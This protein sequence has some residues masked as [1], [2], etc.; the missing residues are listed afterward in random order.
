ML[1]EDALGAVIRSAGDQLILPERYVVDAERLFQAGRARS[2]A[3]STVMWTVFCFLL[4]A[5]TVVL[6]S[7]NGSVRTIAGVPIPAILVAG[8]FGTFVVLL[9][10]I[11][12]LYRRVRRLASR[13]RL[14]LFL[15]GATPCSRQFIAIT[16][17]S[18]TLFHRSGRVSGN[19]PFREVIVTAL[20]Q[21]GP[22]VSLVVATEDTFSEIPIAL[23]IG[24]PT[25]PFWSSGGILGRHE[26]CDALRDDLRESGYSLASV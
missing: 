21:F 24:G 19:W 1:T 7:S 3:V 16:N 18:I 13:P 11:P 6:I 5:V 8:S 9:W 25:A 14:R 12:I 20:T 15:V 4:I 26:L 23:Q 10:R 17:S 2:I 22:A